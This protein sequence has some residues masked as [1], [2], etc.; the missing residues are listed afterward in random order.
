M[1]FTNDLTLQPETTQADY[2]ANIKAKNNH[3]S[4]K[5]SNNS[6][7]SVISDKKNI[8]ILGDSMIKHVNGYDMSKKLLC[9]LEQM[10]WIAEDHPIL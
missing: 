7:T 6:S 3:R 2:M 8:V 9:T 4:V 1:P 5:K 10:T